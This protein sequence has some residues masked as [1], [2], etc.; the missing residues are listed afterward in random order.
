MH[1]L[2]N[3]LKKKVKLGNIGA[4]YQKHIKGGNSLFRLTRVLQAAGQP[5]LRSN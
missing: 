1:D 5:L 4:E 3:W 2:A